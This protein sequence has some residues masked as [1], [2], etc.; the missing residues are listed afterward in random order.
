[1]PGVSMAFR[2][3][4]R[5][6]R[7]AGAILRCRVRGGGQVDAPKSLPGYFPFQDAFLGVLLRFSASL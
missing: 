2:R 5:C 4:V 6:R 1:M 3:A 7:G